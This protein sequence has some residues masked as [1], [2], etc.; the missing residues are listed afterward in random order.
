M[1][2]ARVVDAN[3]DSAKRLNG[4]GDSSL[5]SRARMCVYADTVSNP[6]TGASEAHYGAAHLDL[7]LRANVRGDGQR[8]AA[9]FLNRLRGR[10]DRTRES[11]VRHL[12][13]GHHHDVCAVAS[14]AQR[15]GEAD[16]WTRASSVSGCR[17]A[18]EKQAVGGEWDSPRDAPVMKSV[19]PLSDPA[20]RARANFSACDRP[21][22]HDPVARAAPRHIRSPDERFAPPSAAPA[23]ALACN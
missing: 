8:S 4:L 11:L 9:G 20:L 19:L 17:E 18:R 16:S 5:S 3:I 1:N 21:P 14:C 7:L 6:Q 2:G 22:T 13:L 15:N 12:G 10:I 23:A